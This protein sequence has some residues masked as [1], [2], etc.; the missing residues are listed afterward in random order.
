MKKYIL[1]LCTIIGFCSCLE[2]DTVDTTALPLATTT[3]ANTFGCLVDGWVYVGG[4]YLGWGHSDVWT[5]DSFHYDKE[6][7]KLFVSVSVKPDFSIR[8]TISAPKEGGECTITDVKFGE[9]E[10]KDGTAT[11]SHFDPKMKIISA[12]FGNGKRLTNGRFDIHYTASETEPGNA[13][14]GVEP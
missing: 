2:D 7:D 13:G 10:L 12:T 9:E 5:H 11:I 6:E 3:G 4:R 14:N 8:F 1:I